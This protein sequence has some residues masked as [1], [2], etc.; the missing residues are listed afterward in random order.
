MHEFLQL[1][2]G[3]VQEARGL[4]AGM[5]ARCDRPVGVYGFSMGG[6]LALLTAALQRLDGPM[7]A[8]A[9]SCT[10]ASVFLDG[11]LAAG[12]SLQ[13]LGEDAETRLRELLD[14]FRVTSLPPPPAASRAAI[15]A[16]RRDGIVPP[17]EPAAI[18]RHWGAPLTW[19][20]TGHVGAVTLHRA[21]VR[22][23]LAEA[24]RL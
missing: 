14:R 20:E 7:V 1:G 21:R 22:R 16:G 10:P 2:F 15:I 9:P 13:A 12:S 23:T 5:R 17:S 18:A 4:L 19:L 8:V 11:M 24:F 3:T 6:H